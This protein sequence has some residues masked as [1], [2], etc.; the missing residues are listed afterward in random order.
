MIL[1][2]PTV[3]D[4]ARMHNVSTYTIRR[5]ERDGFIPLAPRDARTG[6]RLYDEATLQALSLALSRCGERQAKEASS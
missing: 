2:K 3:A 5:W 4:V 6:Y 1:G